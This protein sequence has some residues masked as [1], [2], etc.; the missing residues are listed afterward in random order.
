[1]KK[2]RCGC[3]GRDECVGELLPVQVRGAHGRVRECGL[4]PVYKQIDGTHCPENSAS[5]RVSDIEGQR[6]FVPGGGTEHLRHALGG[7]A[8]ISGQI[9]PLLAGLGF[10]GHATLAEGPADDRDVRPGAGSGDGPAGQCAGSC[11]EVSE[12]PDRDQRS[13][14]VSIRNR[15]SRMGAARRQHK[16]SRNRH[17]KNARRHVMPPL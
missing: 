10:E 8:A 9:E 1:M 3:T 16:T 13:F 11:V 2:Q 12:A 17:A 7:V 15:I 4:R 6:V 14:E 5:G